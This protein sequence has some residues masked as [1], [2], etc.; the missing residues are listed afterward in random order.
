MECL[1]GVG[2][3]VTLSWVMPATEGPI[4]HLLQSLR[5]GAARLL[6]PEVKWLLVVMAFGSHDLDLW[7]G[8]GGRGIELGGGVG[9][10]EVRL[11]VGV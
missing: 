6:Y 8:G 10:G 11:G 3:F 4:L 1:Q 9:V 2:L 7:R 5:R